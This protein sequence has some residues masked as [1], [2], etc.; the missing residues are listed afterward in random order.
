[1]QKELVEDI[2][3]LRVKHGSIQVYRTL[4][5]LLREE[6]EELSVLFC[7][8]APSPPTTSE[9]Y[10]EFMEVAA[11]AA[12]DT[13]QEQHMSAPFYEE[14][15]EAEDAASLGLEDMD[16]VDTIFQSLDESDTTPPQTPPPVKVI[17]TGSA[18]ADP[19]AAPKKKILKKRVPSTEAVS[20]V[21][22]ES[23]CEYNDIKLS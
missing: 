9:Y 19:P 10:R 22:E 18:E 1:M 7:S 12:H 14:G 11:Q 2:N 15:S 8:E 4:L 17:H 5:R 6:Y 21:K 13:L 16:V 3:R 20:V 23:G